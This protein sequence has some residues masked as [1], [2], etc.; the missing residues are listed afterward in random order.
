[1]QAKGPR[2][3][4]NMLLAVNA[5]GM[6]CLMTVARGVHAT[7]F[8]EFLKSLMTDKKRKVF[9]I[10][11]AH[12]MHKAKLVQQFVQEHGVAIGLFFLPPYAPELNP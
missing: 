4:L 3:L 1:V 12:P 8:R 11:D 5:Q 7:V 6:F 9:W 2:F 10:V